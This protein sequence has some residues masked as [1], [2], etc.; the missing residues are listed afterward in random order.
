MEPVVTDIDDLAIKEAHLPQVLD[1]YENLCD[2]S[3]MLLSSL[4]SKTLPIK[5]SL[6]P[7]NW[8]QG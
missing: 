2:K 6:S 4:P 1:E 8:W 5:K 7:A 3:L